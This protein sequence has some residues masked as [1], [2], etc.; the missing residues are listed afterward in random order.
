MKFRTYQIEALKMSK[1][2]YRG[3]K[4]ERGEEKA[5]KEWNETRIGARARCSVRPQARLASAPASRDQLDR[6]LNPRI[7]FLKE[8]NK[9]K[10]VI[11]SQVLNQGEII[12]LT[13]VSSRVP[14]FEQQMS[15]TAAICAIYLWASFWDH[16]CP[17]LQLTVP[18]ACSLL[19]KAVF[20]PS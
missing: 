4:Y 16:L 15:K 2:G 12:I 1:S 6:Q 8:H 20:R 7:C 18:R 10:P 5:K 19:L 13:R 3:L 17:I 14:R 11:I 9:I